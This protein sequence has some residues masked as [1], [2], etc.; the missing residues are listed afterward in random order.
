MTS[1]HLF[2]VLSDTAIVVTQDESEDLMAMVDRSLKQQR[3]GVLS[4]LE[5]EDGIPSRVLD[6]LIENF[7]IGRRVVVRAAGRMGL[8]DW[9]ALARLRRP[10]LKDR[11]FAPTVLWRNGDPE[12]FEEIKYRDQLVHHPFDSF[13]SVEAFVDAAVDDPGVV[14]IKMTL[15]R[16][17]ANSPL[18]DRLITAA[19]RGKQVAVLVELKARFDERSNMEWAS[20]LEEAGVHVVHGVQDLKTHCKICLV[21]RQEED[22]IRRYVHVATGNYNRATAHVYTDVGLFTANPRIVADVSELFNYLT[23]YSNQT[24]YRELLVAPI[25]LRRRFAKLVAR[26]I[27]HARQGRPARIIVKCNSLCD[28][29]HHPDAVSRVTGRRV[30]R[31]DR[32]RHLRAAPGRARRQREH[33]RPLDRRPPARALAHLVFRERRQARNLHRQRRPDGAQPEHAGRGRLPGARSGPRRV[34]PPR[35]SRGVSARQR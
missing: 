10:G 32:P 2:R 29:R 21:V 8:A 25:A 14:A 17:G 34:H 26:E 12:I 22:G 30:D 5:V 13:V 28:V 31:P 3:H 18:V 6:T 24:D 20:R 16:I 35:H 9:I 27:T 7:E 15:Y 1:A 23:G 19:H 4:L 33:P 11:A